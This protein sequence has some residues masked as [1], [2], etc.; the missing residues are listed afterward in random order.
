MKDK[1]ALV[2]GGSKGM[3]EAAVRI[4]AEKGASVAI[5]DV[6]MEAAE[7]L[8]IELN[9]NGA[10]TIAIQC[11]VSSEAEV[12]KAIA[13]VVE[14][15]GKLDAA[16]NNAGIQI[17]AQDITETSE[18]DY[19]KI[20]NVNLKGVWLCMKHELIQMK[21][22]QSGAIV[23]NSSLAGKVGVPGRTPY[24]AAKHAIL[25]ITK[26]AAAD[27]ASKGIRIN[28]VCPG[29]IETPMVNDMVNSGD[30]KREDSINAAPINR[31][32]KAS[33]VADAA[34]WLCGEESTYVIGQSIA[35]DGGYT[36]L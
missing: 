12:E 34:V 5:L 21:K 16:F 28:A 35:V 19:D 33:E 32:G 6:D 14:T 2:T 3:G 29:T 8:S 20:L 27:Y 7:K 13:K 22:Q 25:G 26:S 36:I 18:E 17:P 10:N 30:L 1:V 11:D 4:F 23:N 15:Y 9:E 31:L 24:V